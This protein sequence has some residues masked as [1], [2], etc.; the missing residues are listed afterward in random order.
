[1]PK[2]SAAYYKGNSSIADKPRDVLV[3]VQR[4]GWRLR[5]IPFPD[6]YYTVGLFDLD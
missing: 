2:I 6:I 3:Q 4:H 1:L 5:N